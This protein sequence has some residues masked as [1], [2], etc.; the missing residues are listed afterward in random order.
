MR[1]PPN[2]MPASW[3]EVAPTSA[4]LQH[5]GRLHFEVVE[6]ARQDGAPASSMV[7]ATW[8]ISSDEILRDA[9]TDQVRGSGQVHGYTPIRLSM[10]FEALDALS[11]DVAYRHTDGLARNLIMVTASHYNSIKM[12]RTL[13]GR[14]L[15]VRCYVTA[16]ST[17]S[18]EVRTDAL[19]VNDDGE[20]FLVNV[21]HT[22]MVAL[23]KETMRPC[24]TGLPP[25]VLPTAGDSVD[26]IAA[27]ER[28]ELARFHRE[29]RAHDAEIEMTTHTRLGAASHPP[30][31]EEMESVHLLHRA[32][33]SAKGS[34]APRLDLPDEVAMQTHQAATVVFPDSRNMHG[35]AFGGFVMR[36]AYDLGYLAARYFTRGQP[37]VPLGIDEAIFVLP[38][39]IGD[40]TRFTARVVHS[41]E[42]GVFRVFVTMDVI[43]PT[44]PDRLPQRTN[45]MMFVFAA[46]PARRRTVLPGTYQEILMHVKGARE[47]ARRGVAPSVRADLAHFFRESEGQNEL[48]SSSEVL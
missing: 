29:Q 20:E 8:P 21:C 2:T 6:N 37:F 7:Q 23:E 5:V 42:D 36:R 30:T 39:A 1:K 10:F 11:A 40:M 19:Q 32:A 25:L 26:T 43:D 31:T 15:I 4:R 46:N 28:Q 24:K 16:V 34:P 13:S 12:R 47:H 38:V 9:V 17:S 14:D 3:E 41:G 48:A 22:V 45:K 35:R 27:G 18:L 44:D 33:V